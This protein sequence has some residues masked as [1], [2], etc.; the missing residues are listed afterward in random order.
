MNSDQ[1]SKILAKGVS[2]YIGNNVLAMRS[3]NDVAKVV[4]TNNGS[5]CLIMWDEQ[6]VIFT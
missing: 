4:P 1:N 5:E 3:E 6:F 2:F